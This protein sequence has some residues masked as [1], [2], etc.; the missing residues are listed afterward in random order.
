MSKVSDRQ[1]NRTLRKKKRPTKEIPK[2]IER[3]RMVKIK[4]KVYGLLISL[5]YGENEL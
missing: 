1:G 2:V 5:F 4:L 3:Q